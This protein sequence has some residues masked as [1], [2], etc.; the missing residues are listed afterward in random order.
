MSELVSTAGRAAAPGAEATRPR[1]AR[2]V[3][4][5]APQPASTRTHPLRLGLSG[6]LAFYNRRR[7]HGSLGRQPPVARLQALRSNVAGSYS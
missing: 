4:R 2:K 1:R 5:H 6:W 3:A 7:P